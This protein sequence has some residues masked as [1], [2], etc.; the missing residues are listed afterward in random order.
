M[1]PKWSDFID[2]FFALHLGE[3]LY[4]NTNNLSKDLQSTKIAAVSRQC[5][6]NVTKE[7]LSKI[8]SDQ[9]F[10]HFLLMLPA[11][12]KACLVNQCFR[13]SDALRPDWRLVLVHQAT[14]YPQTAKD[15]FRRVFYEAI[16]LIV[17]A[18][19]QG[20][21]QESFSSY[22]WMETFLFKAANGDDD[23]AEFKFFEASYSEDVVQGCYLATKYF[24]SYVKGGEDIMF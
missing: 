17:R 23:E 3:P 19:D 14:V 6:A 20:V 16:D 7:T 13:E 24:G 15:H 21:N 10:D 2:F 8:H 18:I 22:T 11:R 5:V 1:R 9:S 4:S 12:V